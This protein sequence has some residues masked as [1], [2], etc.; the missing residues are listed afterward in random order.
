MRSRVINNHGRVLLIEM[1][2]MSVR[3]LILSFIEIRIHRLLSWHYWLVRNL[4]KVFLTV[5][6]VLIDTIFTRNDPFA[7]LH[8]FRF[9]TWHF[10][11]FIIW[12]EEIPI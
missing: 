6:T 1:W 7:R 2:Q 9:G 3:L 11:N 4:L 5:K 10:S 12:I 8:F